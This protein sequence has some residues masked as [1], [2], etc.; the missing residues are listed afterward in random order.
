MCEKIA[1]LEVCLRFIATRLLYVSLRIH[2]IKYVQF[3]SYLI[4]LLL[5]HTE[6]MTFKTRGCEICV[7]GP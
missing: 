7:Q 4:F 1:S 6:F 5:V 3:P 2:R